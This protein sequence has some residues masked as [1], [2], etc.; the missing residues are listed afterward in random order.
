MGITPRQKADEAVPKGDER[1]RTPFEKAK[2]GIVL[3]KAEGEDAGKIVSANPHAAQSHGYTTDELLS[4]S[5]AE[6]SPPANR[7]AKSECFKRM[8]SEEWIRGEVVHQKK[9]GTLFPLE[10]TAGMVEFGG[11]KYFLGIERDTSERKAAELALKESEERYRALAELLPHGITEIDRKGTITYANPA[12]CRMHGYD[13]AEMIGSFI[14]DLQ[15]SDTDR[16]DLQCYLESLFNEQPLPEPWIGTNMRKDGAP[17]QVQVDWNYRRD[18]QGNITG[19]ISVVTDI[20]ER[21][22]AEL[23]LRQE[24]LV[25]SALA[26]LYVPLLSAS[27]RI[28][29]ISDIVLDKAKSLTDSE[30]GYVGLIHEETGELTCRTFTRMTG[31]SVE[32]QQRQT[33]S[34][35]RGSDGRYPTLRGHALNE[36]RAFYTNCPADHPASTGV[37][38]EHIPINRFLSVPVII[39]DDLVGQISLANPSRDYGEKDLQAVNRLADFYALAINRMRAEEALRESELRFRQVAENIR[40]VFWL[41]SAGTPERMMYVSPAFQDLFARREEELY[42]NPSTWWDSIVESDRDAVLDAYEQCVEGHGEFKKEYRICRPDGS[43]RWVFDTAFPIRDCDGKIFRIAGLARDVTQH[44]LDQEKERLLTEELKNFAFVVSHDLRAPIVTIKGFTNVLKEA[45][46]EIQTLVQGMEAHMAEPDQIRLRVAME[47]DVSEAL[48]FIDSSTAQM[49]RLITAI[50]KLSRTGRRELEF[51][52]VDMESLV[53]D[54]LDS[55]A[56]QISTTGSQ[57]CVGSLPEI[58]ADRTSMEQIMSN[59]VT[60][61]VHYLEEDRPGRIQIIGER[62]VDETVFRVSDNGIG[63]APSDVTRVFDIFRRLT[64]KNVGGEGMGLAHV[65]TL[66]RRH[67][68]RIWCESDPGIGTTFTFTISNH[69]PPGTITS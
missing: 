53:R 8:L 11:E 7:G 37:P 54:V 33:I 10:V 22:R 42:N 31:D 15:P 57:I 19:L 69:L 66:V 55:L 68:G 9:D 21:H 18:E 24:L 3:V 27:A 63:I 28:E 67:G 36:R 44:K 26:D 49:D 59:L 14:L 32:G 38:P 48:K 45:M 5:I 35:S 65:R 4:M 61:A 43:V 39:E 52:P 12:Y 47:N 64:T 17:V 40:A 62:G 58:V 1:C 2:H 29:D 50:L 16:T 6:L 13:S 46:E 60:N 56:H 34:F 23:A 20:T 51:E 25:S 30:H 41:R